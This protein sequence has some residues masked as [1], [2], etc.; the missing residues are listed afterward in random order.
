MHTRLQVLRMYEYTDKSKGDTCNCYLTWQTWVFSLKISDLASGSYRTNIP[1][2]PNIEF[3]TEFFLILEE[4]K[5][6]S[7]NL[8]YISRVFNTQ[9]LRIYEILLLFFAN[10]DFLIIQFVAFVYI[11]LKFEIYGNFQMRMLYQ[12]LIDNK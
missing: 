3:I 11:G 1:R 12:K 7:S 10:S 9:K 6:R 8:H 4:L 5:R 2:I